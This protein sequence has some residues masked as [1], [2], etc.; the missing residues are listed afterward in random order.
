MSLEEAIAT[1]KQIHERRQAGGYMQD[2]LDQ[3]VR[4][5]FANG[6]F[7]DSEEDAGEIVRGSLLGLRLRRHPSA[8][9]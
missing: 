3:A 8:N 7:E 9:H 4:E 5:G 2:A 1:A 6:A